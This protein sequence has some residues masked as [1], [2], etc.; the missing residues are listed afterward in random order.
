MATYSNVELCQLAS[1]LGGNC[2][3]DNS[4]A[5]KSGDI[6]F[7]SPEQLVGTRGR[8]NLENLYVFRDGAVRYVTTLT[9]GS[10]CLRR[11]LKKGAAPGR[12]REC[13]SPPTAATWPS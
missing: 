8:P 7:F 11:T 2:R 12:W 3:S 9:P 5:A 1:G 13:R 6:Y 4:I 10:Y